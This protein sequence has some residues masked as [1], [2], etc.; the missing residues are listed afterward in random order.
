MAQY[1]QIASIPGVQV[2][3]PIA[4]VG[5]SLLVSQL[6]FPLPTA[7]LSRPG[8]QLYRVTTT[9]ISQS[10]A[11]RAAE[12]PSFVYVT[13]QPL[14]VDA[15]TGYLATERLPDGTSVT[16]CPADA[17]LE[18]G[19]DPFGAA[20]QSDCTAWSK[21][22][23]YGP[24][25]PLVP[26]VSPANPGYHVDWVIPVLIAAV[27]PVAEA[28]LDG[29]N[30]AVISGHY[31]AEHAAGANS[32]TFPVLA[33]SVSGLDESAVTQ[34]AAL[35]APV[36]ASSMTASWITQH[37]TAPG[38]VISAITTTAHQ[39]YQQLQ[40]AL[41]VKPG[42]AA[43][44]VG[45]GGTVITYTGKMEPS[46]GG[47]VGIHAYWSVGPT[48]YR[49]LRSGTLVAQLTHNPP[50]TWYTGGAQ[51]ASMDDED[52]QCRKVSVH[53]PAATTFTSVPAGPQLV[54]IFN[55]R[56]STSSTRCRACRSARMSLWSPPRRT[57]Q[58]TGRCT[59]AIC[60]QIRI[61]ADT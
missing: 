13:P 40:A 23:G 25:G 27:D 55:R 32:S 7:D 39:A 3:A 21:V 57:R 52:N 4:M 45:G 17:T 10:G 37:A 8:R 1:R 51:T 36:S 28:E 41:A 6:S 2:A 49:R 19:V 54:G 14:G 42:P 35:S 46:I 44:T 11:S 47:R 56:R 43:P 20:A 26:G 61:W 24:A 9:W 50:S 29:L 34:L 31:L 53:A 58:Q 22:N 60:C 33:S 16:I 12:P 48:S 59:A 18:P 38:Q 5:Y 30:R 15:Q